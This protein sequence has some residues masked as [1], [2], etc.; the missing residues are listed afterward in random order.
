LTASTLP[1]AVASAAISKT[2]LVGNGTSVVVAKGWIAEK[3][4][5]GNEELIHLSPKA[6]IAIETA[7][8]I[9]VSPQAQAQVKL[10]SVAKA[11]LMKSVKVTNAQISQI[12]GNG[13]FDEVYSFTYTG[14]H[15]GNYGGLAAEFQNSKTGDACF[16]MSIAAVSEKSKLKNSINQIINS[17]ASNP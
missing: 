11:F 6:V 7:T 4:Q 17:V 3:P 14:K 1:G 15:K 13:K 5:A 12:P 2:S 8:G 9:T 16:A 10:D